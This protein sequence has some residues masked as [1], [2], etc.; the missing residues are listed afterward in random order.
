MRRSTIIETFP[1]TCFLLLFNIA[2]FFLE[3]IAQWRIAGAFP[4]FVTGGIGGK[5]AWLLGSLNLP[6]VKDGEYW[7]LV[8]ATF[9]HGFGLHLLLNMV[10]LW[11]LGRYCEPLLSPWKFIFVYLACALG[12]SAGS[13]AWSEFALDPRLAQMRSSV[14]ASGA[15]FGLVGVLLV[16]AYRC[17]HREM[18]QA[19]LRW[20][21]YAVVITLAIPGID[22]AGH[23]GGFVVGC[24]FGLGVGDYI[25]SRAAVRWRWPGYAAAAVVVAA[26]GL[27]I[28]HYLL[29]R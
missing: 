17:G 20:V 23:A 9:L 2:L 10:A 13:L 3:C 18:Y 21:G 5:A 27:A 29:N 12:G 11:D 1:V 4:S 19:F 25:G 28:R 8:S 7:R 16:H 26:L 14:G 6:D 22:H 24:A 15:L